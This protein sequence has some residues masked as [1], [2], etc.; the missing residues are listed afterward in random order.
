MLDIPSLLLLLTL[1]GVIWFWF[2]TLKARE[3][4]VAAASRACSEEGLLFLDDTVVGHS[5]GFVR[6]D[7]GR[8][9][10]RRV[11][12]FEYS[13]TGDNRRSG[14]V[15]LIG[16]DVELLH[17]RPKLYVVPPVNEQTLH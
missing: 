5:V 17:I 11:Y 2:D 6:D 8:L 15:T 7:E 1:G 16:H 4:G 12:V 10:L 3:I 9:R 13:D 14:S